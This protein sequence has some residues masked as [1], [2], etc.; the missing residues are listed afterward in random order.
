VITAG[1]PGDGEVEVQELAKVPLF[2]RL[3]RGELDQVA[4]IAKRRSLGPD[5]VIFFEG[6]PS[7]ALYVLLSGSMKVYRTAD[8]GT[9]QIVSTLVAGE[10]FGEY[11]LLDGEPRSATVA[12]LEPSE[13]LSIS[14]GAFRDL[15]RASPS[16]LWKTMESLTTRMRR[17]NQEF[18]ELSRRDLPYRL[19][20]ALNRLAERHGEL[21]GKGC[22]LKIALGA[23]DLAAMVASTPERVSA[24]LSRFEAEGLLVRQAASAGADAGTAGA[25]RLVIP[26]SSAFARALQYVTD[27]S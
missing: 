4:G 27:W 19:L 24:L 13:V 15:V 23:R 10:M 18:L 11:S 6:D 12:T 25:G 3:S 14:H 5:A 16:L 17:Q 9:Q 8:D 21:S 26:D 1:R 7:D 2:G 20:R 22:R